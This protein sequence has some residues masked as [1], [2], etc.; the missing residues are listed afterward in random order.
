M[1]FGVWRAELYADQVALRIVAGGRIKGRNVSLGDGV[2]EHVQV[3]RHGDRIARA[4]VI[5]D[6]AS[7]VRQLGWER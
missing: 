5:V 7:A 4:L 6:P 2:L 3:W 1:E